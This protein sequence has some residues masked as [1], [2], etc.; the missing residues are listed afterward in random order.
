MRSFFVVLLA[1]LA[2]CACQ[3]TPPTESNP[4][5]LQTY[6]VPKGSVR[7]LITTMKDAFWVDEKTAPVGRA[8]ITPDGRLM[9]VAPRNVQTGVQTLVDQVTKHPPTIDSTI[10][11]H[12]W[13][14]MGRATPTAAPASAAL[15]EV[16]PAL[17][18]IV[19]AQGPQTFTLVQ[20]V[21]LS[22]LQ[23]EW[24]KAEAAP[25]DSP[26]S[27]LVIS[28][29]AVQSDDGV[30]GQLEIHYGKNDAIETRVNLAPGQ[31]IVLGTTGQRMGGVADAGDGDGATLYYLVRVAAR[32][33]GK[34][35]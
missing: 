2:L 5:E 16:E 9:V 29:H 8:T 23:D 26:T 22:S 25:G 27:K 33:D 12:Y 30:F 17:D 1:A 24:G 7:P 19:R 35:P 32:A 3:K 14:V 13:L 20:H 4:V 28:Q 10:E 6:D 31:T 18:E 11:L 34:H 21:Q 15:K